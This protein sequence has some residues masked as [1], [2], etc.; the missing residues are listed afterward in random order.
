MIT[1]VAICTF[2]FGGITLIALLGTVD[3]FLPKPVARARQKL[4]AV[5]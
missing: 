5:R 3:L 1:T 4:E 2:L